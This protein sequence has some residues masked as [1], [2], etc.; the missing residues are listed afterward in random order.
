MYFR[1]I[2]AD[3][4]FQEKMKGYLFSEGYLFTGFYG[5]LRL[6]WKL[7]LG[8]EGLREKLKPLDRFQVSHFRPVVME[9]EIGGRSE[10]LVGKS[11]LPSIKNVW[12]PMQARAVLPL[13]RRPKRSIIARNDCTSTGNGT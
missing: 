11:Q 10:K 6:M 9:I 8:E 13:V 4:K 3:S 2:A 1:G 5:S 12:D 7:S